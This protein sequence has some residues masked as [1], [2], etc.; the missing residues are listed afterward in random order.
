MGRPP[1]MLGKFP[2][3]PA[4]LLRAYLSLREIF[5]VKII[6]RTLGVQCK[7]IR[8]GEACRTLLGRDV[9]GEKAHDCAF[10][11]FYDY[12]YFYY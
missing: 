8:Y 12:F 11:V 7:Y 10:I 5:N 2:N 4:F 6:S 1:P 3:N 9:E